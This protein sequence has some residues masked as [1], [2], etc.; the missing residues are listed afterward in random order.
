MGRTPELGLGVLGCADIAW[1]RAL[2]AMAALPDVRVA[3]LAGRDPAKTRR[4]AGRFGGVPLRTHEEV[5]ARD[6]VSA[7]YV[8]LPPALHAEWIERALRAGKHVLAEKPLTT[9]RNRTVGLVAMAR[10]AGL[11]LTENYTFVHHGQHA[12]VWSLVASGAIG[13][14]EAFSAVFAIPRRPPGDFRHR[15]ALG[16]GALW[17]VGGYPVRA[18]RMFFPGP[19]EV[20]D[21]VLRRPEGSEVDTGGTARIRLAGGRSAYLRFGI[22]DGYES[23]YEIR[24]DRGR[25]TV[26]H[27]FTP[28]AGHR[29]AVRLDRDGVTREFT[30]DPDDQWAR[31]CRAFADA[32]TGG[33]TPGAEPLEQAALVDE[34]RARSVH[35]TDH[36][37][38]VAS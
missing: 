33:V 11:A 36:L 38:E 35:D 37:D 31:A 8:A 26:A 14:P 12:A 23:A 7:V 24:G 28:P 25:I 5:L 18:L 19:A 1:R 20:A 27:V 3:A 6:D 30:L 22:D 29:P 17:D 34:I 4:F 2:P 32:A 13:T 15:A 10:S 21:A 9:S 16:G